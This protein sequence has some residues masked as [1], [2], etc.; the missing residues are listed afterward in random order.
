MPDAPVL[1]I[2]AGLAGLS[3]ATELA[4]A[5]L[6]VIVVDQAAAAGGAIHR[7]PLPGVRSVASRAQARRWAAV[8]QGIRG[9]GER[10]TLSLGTQ[11]GG[12]DH[13]GAVL[14]GGALPAL[15]RPR[16]LVLATGARER[17]QPRPGWDLP[18]VMTAGAIQAQIK[19]LGKAPA[20]RVLLAGSGPLLLA[21]GAEL[22]RLGNPPV[23]IVEAARPFA[24]PIAALGLPLAY[25]SEAT[26]YFVRL[27]A[28][29]VPML[30]ASHLTWIT[31]APDHLVAQ[32]ET[33]DSERRF[34]ID[35]IGLHDGIAP[36]D[37]GLTDSAALPVIWLGDCR[38]AL[39]A[40]AALAD[41]RA[42]GAAL[43]AQLTGHAAPPP[44][45][46]LSRQQQSQALLARLYAHDGTER[47]RD[48]PAETVICR[49]ENRTLGDL[50]ALGPQ[51]SIRELR[52]DGRFAMGGCQGRFCAEWVGRLIDSDATAPP[53][54]RL[55]AARWP[56][57]PIAVADLLAAK[58][59]IKG[60]TR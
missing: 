52:L 5:G 34:R 57:R 20:G 32:I 33:P 55:G 48:L 41:G 49:C 12:L 11:F 1:V 2:G 13:T 29:G 58:T 26:R 42:G 14:L 56:A 15:I 24:N 47:L 28:A 16:A 54:T 39:G 36:N 31:A 35:H 19:T 23:A 40:A 43:A 51:P 10:I 30:T 6:P 50:R 53:L 46:A 3:A 60:K 22:V 45:R 9:Q 37:I 59:D 25:L 7:Q 18:G 8:M 44:S 4:R 17:V 27:K 38:Q 21:V